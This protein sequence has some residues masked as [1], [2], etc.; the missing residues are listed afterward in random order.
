MIFLG[1]QAFF[2]SKKLERDRINA[3]WQIPHI[4]LQKPP[5]RE[6][7]KMSKRSLQSA[8]QSIITDSSK[9]TFESTFSNYT[10]FY[11]DKD[12]VL[13]TAHPASNLFRSDYEN[14]VKLRKLEHDNVNKFIGMSID[15]AEYIAVW[16]MCMRG[17]LLVG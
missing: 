1:F 15:G 10:I 16:K 12:P 2:S 7:D 11:L 13:T 14:F 9:M 8:H 5:K 6:K 3:E 4:K 17:S